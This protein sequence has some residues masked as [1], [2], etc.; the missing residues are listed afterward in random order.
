M[1][2]DF[3]TIEEKQLMVDDF[4][5]MINDDQVG[6]SITYKTFVSK[7]VFDPITGKVVPVFTDTVI[8]AIRMP[9]TEKEVS[10]SGGRYQAGDLRYLIRTVDVPAPKKDDRLVDGVATRY[11]IESSTDT[12]RVFHSVI[13]RNLSGG[14]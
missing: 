1:S 3:L 6:I 8:Q 2:T 12:L 7:G 11:V 10:D 13:V 5:D 14:V 4:H 9:I